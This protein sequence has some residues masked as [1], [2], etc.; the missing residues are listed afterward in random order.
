MGS[1]FDSTVTCQLNRALSRY[2]DATGNALGEI[3]SPIQVE[4]CIREAR[5]CL[6]EEGYIYIDGGSTRDVFLMPEKKHVVKIQPNGPSNNREIEMSRREVPCL[7]PVLEHS[8]CG[9]WLVMPF[10]DEH[11]SGEVPAK[12]RAYVEKQIAQ[13]G[14]TVSE[15]GEIRYINNEPHICDYGAPWK[16]LH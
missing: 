12:D 4:M 1:P 6:T 5:K 2:R 11:P 13:S 8:I 16:K 10:A 9:G 14:W 3:F 7:V 15:L